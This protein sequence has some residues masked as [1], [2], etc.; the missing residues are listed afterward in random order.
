MTPEEFPR[1]FAAGWIAR[2]ADALAALLSEDADMLSLTGAWVE[3]RKAILATLKAELS[4]LFSR[5]RLVTGRSKLRPMGP[6]AAV[7]HQRFVLSGLVDEEGRDMG[8]IGALL[9][10]TLVARP[11]GWQAVALQFSATEG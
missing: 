1:A 9:I 2:D 7:L 8:R 11:E 10:A 5:A 3:G 4:G 6:G